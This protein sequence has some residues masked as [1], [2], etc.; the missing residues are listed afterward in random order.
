MRAAQAGSG[1][2][3][4]CS[5]ACRT[6][7]RERLRM[8]PYARLASSHLRSSIWQMKAVQLGWTSTVLQRAPGWECAG[9]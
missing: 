5:R 3:T 4:G 7:S 9:A 1:A 8:P 2:G 6:R